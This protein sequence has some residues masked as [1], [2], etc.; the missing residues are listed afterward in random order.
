MIFLDN[1]AGAFPK[2]PGTADAVRAAIADSAPNIGRGGYDLAY[3]TAGRVMDVRCRLAAFFGVKDPRR[4][5]F[6]PGCTWGLNMVLR[7][8]LSPGD[9]VRLI[10]W[11]HNAVA[12]PL[13][14]L[15]VSGSETAPVTVVTHGSN[16]SGEIFPIPETDGFV[17]VDAAQTAGVLPI[18]FDASPADAMAIACHKGL[19]AP[20]GAGLLLLSPRMAER[21]TPVITGGTGSFSDSPEMPPVLPDRFEPGTLNL[22]AILGLGAALDFV[23]ANWSDIQTKKAQQTAAIRTLFADIP[24]AKLVK[25]PALPLWSI[26]FQNHDNAEAA[27]RLESE[28]GIITRCGLHCAPAAHRALGTYPQGTVRFSAGYFTTMDELE[29]TANAVKEVAR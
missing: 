25:E 23:S 2:A 19:M 4:V 10:G 18:D 20:A 22:P 3:D 29:Q 26:D 12:R 6:T 5:I 27:Y 14:D 16:V 17:F 7:G 15:Q 13:H 28:F 24:G 9:P 8:L 11:P 1:A 21:L